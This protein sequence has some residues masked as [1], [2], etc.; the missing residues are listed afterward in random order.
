MGGLGWVGRQVN[1][2]WALLWSLE[3]KGG[4]HYHELDVLF[5]IFTFQILYNH[6]FL[7]DLCNGGL[8]CDLVFKKLLRYLPYPILLESHQ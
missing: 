6:V 4:G 1:K 8:T 3:V 7:V 2:G 5:L